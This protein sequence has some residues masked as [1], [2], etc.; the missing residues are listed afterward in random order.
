MAEEAEGQKSFTVTDRRFSKR[1]EEESSEE[2][3]TESKQA[4]EEDPVPAPREEP[5][6]QE[7]REEPS[8]EPPTAD[9]TGFILSLA[10]TALVNMGVVPDPMGGQP[11]VNLDGA[12]QMIDILG[13]I[14]E[15]T[16]GNLTPEEDHILTEILSEVRMR[17]VETVRLSKG[18]ALGYRRRGDDLYLGHN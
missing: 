2:A 18:D 11:A 15:K 1:A 16:R 14:Q 10:N 9:F 8:G 17:Y 6:E 3:P 12:K 13:I 4:P 7:K 5:E